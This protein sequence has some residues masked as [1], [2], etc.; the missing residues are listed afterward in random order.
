MTLGHLIS[1]KACKPN[2]NVSLVHL[3]RFAL[4]GERYFVMD[5]FSVQNILNLSSGMNN[6][7][8]FYTYVFKF[9]HSL[10]YQNREAIL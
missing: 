8:K 7:S 4:A 6:K 9:K 3:Y 10:E 2:H 5:V 1:S